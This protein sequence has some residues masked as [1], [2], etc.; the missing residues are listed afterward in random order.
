[1]TDELLPAHLERH[2][3][4]IAEAWWLRDDRSLSMAAFPGRPVAGATTYASLGLS[5]HDLA[6]YEDD[7]ITH[8]ELLVCA[9]DRWGETARLLLSAVAEQL[10]DDHVPLPAGAVYTFAEPPP[11]ATV[12]GLVSWPPVLHPAGLHE[13]E[14]LGE[15]IEVMWLIPLVGDEW[16]TLR[17]DRVDRPAAIEALLARDD[18]DLLDLGRDAVE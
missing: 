9:W 8:Q 3:G 15:M 1:M 10:V 6:R 13:H 18:V 17:D 5:H 7:P 4:E 14:Q 16:R 2:L 11:G 12:D